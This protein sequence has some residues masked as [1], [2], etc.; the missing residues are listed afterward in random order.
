MISLFSLEFQFQYNQGDNYRIVT[1]VLEDVKENDQ[2]IFS[3]EILNRIAV[4]IGSASDSGG[5]SKIMMYAKEAMIK[6]ATKNPGAKE[7]FS[8][9]EI[10]RM[11]NQL[12]SCRNPY[13]CPQG[14]PIYY[15]L[16]IRDFETRFRR[17]I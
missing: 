15:E 1:E 17:K 7:T 11:A 4:S 8:E 5:E 14:R 12:L 9:N 16:P 3:T 13:T 2:L 6:Q 10:V